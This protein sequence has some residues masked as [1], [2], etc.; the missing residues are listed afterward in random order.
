V[1]ARSWFCLLAK[2]GEQCLDEKQILYR[3]DDQLQSMVDA[4]SSHSL[5]ADVSV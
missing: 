3:V 5:P 4:S 1:L 2:H